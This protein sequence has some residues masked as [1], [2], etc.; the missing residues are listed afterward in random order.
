MLRSRFLSHNVNDNTGSVS[1]GGVSR[2]SFKF[3]P[4][5]L[6]FPFYRPAVA[7][8]TA[9]PVPS[10]PHFYPF[11]FFLF[12]PVPFSL[13]PTLSFVFSA[14]LICRPASVLRLPC[15]HRCFPDLSFSP[16]HLPLSL[17]CRTTEFGDY[18]RKSTCP[19]RYT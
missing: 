2:G 19:Y 17:L 9:I 15:Y 8:V 16:L 3:G 4:F 18:P 12:L 5:L 6:P 1:M 7:R 14:N 10:L 13:V 11:R